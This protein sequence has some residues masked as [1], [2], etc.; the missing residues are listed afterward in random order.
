M[1]GIVGFSVGLV[2]R[3]VLIVFSVGILL[4]FGLVVCIVVTGVFAVI[5]SVG[6]VLVA[7]GRGLG[8]SG[9]AWS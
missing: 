4:R 2:V 5:A 9:L 3:V 6:V 1:L 8:V 7:G